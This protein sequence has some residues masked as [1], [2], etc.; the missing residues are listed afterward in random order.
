MKKIFTSFALLAITTAAHAQTTA[1]N[2]TAADCN[3]VSHTLFNDLDNNKVVVMVW[4]MPCGSCINGAKAAYNTVQS[5]ASTNPGKVLLYLADDN[6]DDNCTALSS[7][8]S[9]NNIG[10]N[11]TTFSNAGNVIKESDFGGS[12]MPHVAVMAGADHKI[13]FNKL[14]AAANDPTG[15]QNAINSAIAALNVTETAG[16]TAFTVSPNPVAETMNIKCGVAIKEVVIT[17]MA[18]QVVKLQAFTKAQ[19]NPVIDMNSIAAGT[20]IISVTDANGNL[21][22]GI[23]KIVKQ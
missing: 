2:W 12:G 13:Y 3:S 4:V 10:T 16:L 19:M 5:Y 8:I 22:K 20:Y 9:S 15:I 14:N 23:Q 1:T 6:G 11:I 17:D 21:G 18:G 7:W